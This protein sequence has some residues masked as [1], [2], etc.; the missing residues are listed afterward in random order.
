MAIKKAFKQDFKDYTLYGVE[1]ISNIV[2]REYNNGIRITCVRNQSKPNKYIGD[3]V[4]I[5]QCFN[6]WKEAYNEAIKELV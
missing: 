3:D 2:C 4:N 6:T 1:S 5:E